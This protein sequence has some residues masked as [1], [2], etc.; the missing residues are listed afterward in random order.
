M[1]LTFAKYPPLLHTVWLFK[2]LY[3][4]PEEIKANPLA[5]HM[6]PMQMDER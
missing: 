1:T 4:E 3:Y 5:Q 6:I 2:C